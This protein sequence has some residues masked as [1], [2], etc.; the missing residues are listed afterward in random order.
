VHFLEHLREGV[1][2]GE[3]TCSVRIWQRPHVKPGNRYR[4]GD[5]QIEVDTLQ[6]I[7]LADITPQLARASGFASVVD[8]LKTAQHGRG[9]NVYLVRFHYVP[10]RAKR[11]GVTAKRQASSVAKPR[12]V[13]PARSARERKRLSR[14]LDRLP[15]A[16][17]VPSGTHLSLEVRKKRFGY[18]LEDHHG[19]GRIAIHCKASPDVHEAMHELAPDQV[20]VPAY[21]GSRG[22]IGLWLDTTKVVASAVELALREAYLMVAP[23]TLAV[24]TRDSKFRA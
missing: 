13:D 17:A 14:I 20:H 4:M 5:G 12:K 7:E 24:T 8:L 9:T 6:Q 1:R 19:D 2:R 21:L 18:F 23:K 22:W 3:I 10:A 15:E 11:G 16:V